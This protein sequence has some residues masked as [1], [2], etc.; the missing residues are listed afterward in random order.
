MKYCKKCG[1]LLED[2]IDICIGCGTDVSDPE[3]VSKYPPNMEKKIEAEKK[4]NKM[5]TTTI[6]A[7]IVVFVLLIGLVCLIIFLAPK[8]AEDA[9]VDQTEVAEEYPEEEFPDEEY[10][11]EEPVEEPETERVV[12]DSQGSYYARTELTDEGGNLIFTGLYPEDFEVTTLSVNYGFC[13]NRLPGYVTF[14]VDDHDNSVRFIYFSP[15]HFWY[16]Q[17]ENKRSLQDGEDPI[18]QMTFATYDEGKTYIEK[19]IKASYPGAKKVEMVDSWEAGEEVK[20]QLSEIAKAFKKQINTR[21]DYAHLGTGTEYAPMNAESKALFYR[22]EVQTKEKD[23]L[24]ME[25]YV[26]LVCNNIIYSSEQLNDHG[27]LMEW[28]CLGVY[29]MVAG[30]EDLYDD[31]QQ[32]FQI[33]KDN[34]NVNQTFFNILDRRVRDLNVS[35]S[36]EQ[37]PEDVTPEKLSEYGSASGSPLGDFMQMIYVFSTMRGG[38]KVFVLDQDIVNGPADTSVAFINR[39]VSKVFF[40]PA[41]DEYPG[42]GYEDMILDEDAGEISADDVASLDGEPAMDETGEPDPDAEYPDA[43]M[44]PDDIPT[45]DQ[46]DLLDEEE[47]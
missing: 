3:N 2:T 7:I 36:E 11:P 16:K 37:E 45:V 8:I 13:S 44:D 21:T 41:E 10:Y 20:D 35:I 26:P 22:Y 25:F 6:I 23:T 5:R 15:Q 40:S 31:Y 4:Q 14:I 39:E 47:L 17:S 30:H 34:C 46:A 38:D 9:M 29:G 18:F 33:F 27:T 24:F 1:T 42:S 32:D 19:L 43:D 12:K 28:I